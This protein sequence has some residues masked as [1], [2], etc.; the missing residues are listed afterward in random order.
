MKKI[1]LF[2][3]VFSLICLSG[4]EKED[5]SSTEAEI[6]TVI[7]IS[8]DF[9]MG[10]DDQ[11]DCANNI[12]YTENGYYSLIQT[13]KISDEMT[14]WM[15]KYYDFASGKQIPV[16]GKVDCNH[17]NVS[18]N[19]YFDNERYPLPNIWYNNQRLYI[20]CVDKDYCAIES[21]SMDGA[22]RDLSCTLYRTNIETGTDE[23]GL[24]FSAVYYPKLMLH[25]GYAYFSTYYPGSEK[26]GLYRVKLDSAEESELICTQEGDYPILYRLKGYGDNIFF[27]KGNFI[28]EA[29]TQVDIDLYAWSPDTGNILEI[30]E[31]VVRDYTIGNNCVYYFD[32]D[33]LDSVM[34]YD[35][36]SGKTTML[37]DSNGAAAYDDTILFVKDGNLYYSSSGFQYVYDESGEMTNTL[38]GT[39]M[40]SPYIPDNE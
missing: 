17:N 38:K 40:V 9:V 2:F 16:C 10:T 3:M 27:Q 31:D 36:K 34:K 12:V 28:D 35:L 11:P 22:Q 39:D 20:F 26:C 13:S 37:L 15:M 19:A 29:G 24:S 18:C 1:V 6:Q 25:R 14:G 5:L 21:V 8:P 32:L 7:S 4:C 23:E 30:A 33:N